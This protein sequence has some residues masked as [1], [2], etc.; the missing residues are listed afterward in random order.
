MRG[1]LLSAVAVVLLVAVVLS[2]GRSPAS[3]QAKPGA[4]KLDF[5]HVTAPRPP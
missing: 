4:K 1:R 3:G 2:G 5:P